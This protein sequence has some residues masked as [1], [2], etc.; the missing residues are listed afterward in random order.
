MSSGQS[1]NY[2]AQNNDSADFDPH[3]SGAFVMLAIIATVVLLIGMMALL[4]QRAVTQR[5][6]VNAVIVQGDERWSGVI[7]SIDGPSMDKPL[8]G[9]LDKTNKYVVSFFLDPGMY[10][11]HVRNDDRDMMNPVA[12]TLDQRIDTIGVDLRHADVAPPT[13]KPA[14]QP[15]PGHLI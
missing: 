11:L 8:A 7:L 1:L 9:T 10:Y 2:S 14:T 5:A 12:L 6:P 4:F 3:P 13:T 15:T